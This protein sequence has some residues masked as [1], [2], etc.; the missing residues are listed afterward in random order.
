MSFLRSRPKAAPGVEGVT[1]QL[2]H[3]LLPPPEEVDLIAVQVDVHL[4]I[5]QT[6]PPTERQKRLLELAAGQRRPR[7]LCREQPPQ[8]SSFPSHRPVESFLD[9]ARRDQLEHVRLLECLLELAIRNDRTEVDQ[10]TGRAD[11]GDPVERRYVAFIQAADAM[12]VD[13]A[14]S[15]PPALGRDGHVDPRPRRRQ[16]PPTIRG[17]AVT[18]HSAGPARK[19]RSQQTTLGAQLSMPERVDPAPQ[20]LEALRSHPTLH[21]ARAES[22]FFELLKSDD[23]VLVRRHRRSRPVRRRDSRRCRSFPLI[24]IENLRHPASVAWEALRVGSL[25]YVAAIRRSS[26]GRLGAPGGGPRCRRACGPSARPP[27]PRAR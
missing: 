4:R 10:G 8:C 15:P 9:S 11:D 19:D 1:V 17:R 13:T 21:R 26:P 24:V 2:D 5:G 25:C 14:P 3:P 20:T 12:K 6:T 23:A 27:A 16:D 7:P 22:T 18:Q